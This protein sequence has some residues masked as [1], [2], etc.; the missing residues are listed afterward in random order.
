M[1][2]MMSLPHLARPHNVQWPMTYTSLIRLPHYPNQGLTGYYWQNCKWSKGKLVS[3]CGR[4]ISALLP[5]HTVHPYCS[6]AN[7]ITHCACVS[8]IMLLIHKPRKTDIPCRGYIISWIINI[9]QCLLQNLIQSKA[10]IRQPSRR[11]NSTKQPISCFG[12]FELT[13]L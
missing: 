5:A 8:T 11:V 6:F 10:T 12:L 1:G 2:I 3:Y 7:M 13:V 9:L 4:A